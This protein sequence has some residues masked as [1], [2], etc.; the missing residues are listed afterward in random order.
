ML[1]LLTINLA[2]EFNLCLSTMLECIYFVITPQDNSEQANAIIDDWF[3]FKV[4]SNMAAYYRANCNILSLTTSD[5]S[6]FLEF[7]FHWVE[8]PFIP[9]DSPMFHTL[10]DPC[11]PVDALKIITY[12]MLFRCRIE[13]KRPSCS[14]YKWHKMLPPVSIGPLA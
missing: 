13:N 6:S 5:S 9:N 14:T 3:K 11:I 8:N 10:C 1:A 4:L 7:L 2:F 12:Y